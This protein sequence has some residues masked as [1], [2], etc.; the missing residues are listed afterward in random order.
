M[1]LQDVGVG[2]GDKYA[3][4]DTLPVLHSFDHQQLIVVP[5]LIL[6]LVSLLMQAD[7]F[8]V[9]I[10]IEGAVPFLLAL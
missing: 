1:K 6:Q 2:V 3:I 7:Q 10:L 5:D 9:L 8:L 4:V